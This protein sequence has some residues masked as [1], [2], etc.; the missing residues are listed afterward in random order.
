MLRRREAAILTAKKFRS[1]LVVLAGMNHIH[2][3]IGAGKP[4]RSSH[5]QG[6]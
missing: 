4:T 1:S 5:S 3:K 2:L 6:W